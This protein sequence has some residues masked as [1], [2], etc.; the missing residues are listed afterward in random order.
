MAHPRNMTVP[1][2]LRAVDPDFGLCKSRLNWKRKGRP[3][4]MP[5]C[6]TAPEGVMG[7]INKTFEFCPKDHG[8]KTEIA[9]CYRFR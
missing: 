1:L 7:N 6:L 4:S 5:T 3:F 9:S 2:E 8:L